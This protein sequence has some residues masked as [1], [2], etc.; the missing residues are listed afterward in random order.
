MGRLAPEITTVSKPKINPASAAI[1]EMPKSPS[2]N[3][4][5]ELEVRFWLGVMCSRLFG[6]LK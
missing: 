3:F 4:V 6:A 1:K 5:P 2:E